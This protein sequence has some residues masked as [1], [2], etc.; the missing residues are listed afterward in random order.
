MTGLYA[1]NGCRRNTIV[2]RESVRNRNDAIRGIKGKK[3][4]AK[5]HQKALVQV[6]HRRS[7][8]A[9]IEEKS[10]QQYRNIVCAMNQSNDITL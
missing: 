10:I 4:K 7:I 3:A 2:E 6:S 5:P 8:Q 1:R 9:I